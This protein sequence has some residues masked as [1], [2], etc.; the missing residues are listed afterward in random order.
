MGAVTGLM[1]CQRHPE[2]VHGIVADS[3]FTSFAALGVEIGEKKSYVP[4][5]LIK[6][7]LGYLVDKIK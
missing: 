3:P 6:V 4:N 5:M 2:E 1:F 7:F